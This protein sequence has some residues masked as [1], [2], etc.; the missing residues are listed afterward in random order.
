[1]R[2]AVLLA[3]VP[4]GCPGPFWGRICLG[5]TNNQSNAC[6]VA[7]GAYIGVVSG[8]PTAVVGAHALNH[9]PYDAIR[10]AIKTAPADGGADSAGMDAGA[11]A[12]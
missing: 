11:A 8:T 2:P 10:D 3:L 4:T 9:D 1:M 7:D 5:G 12:K 6:I